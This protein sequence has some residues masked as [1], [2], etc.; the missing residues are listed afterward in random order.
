MQYF[1]HYTV[2]AVI[3]NLRSYICEQFKAMFLLFFWSK[4]SFYALN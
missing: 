2:N 3:F 1:D 4:T